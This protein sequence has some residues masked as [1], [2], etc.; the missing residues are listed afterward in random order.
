MLAFSGPPVP[1]A[2]WQYPQAKT[3]GFL[4]CATTSGM[5]RCSSG[6]QSGAK[7]RSLSSDSVQLAE[8]PGTWRRVPSST[9]ALESGAAMGYAHGG[10]GSVCG[11]AAVRPKAMAAQI[12]STYFFVNQ[13]IGGERIPFCGRV[14]SMK[15]TVRGL[16]TNCAIDP[17]SACLLE[18]SPPL[19]LTSQ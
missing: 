14:L 15:L 6:C 12:E 11:V 2:R 10:G 9:G 13:S 4:P 8:L 17:D 1:S 7:K 5:R 19:Q 16:V 3:S 18:E